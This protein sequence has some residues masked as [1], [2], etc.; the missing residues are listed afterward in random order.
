MFW[1]FVLG[2]VGAI[3]AVPLTITIATLA[4]FFTG[5]VKPAE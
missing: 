3:L 4:P 2:P 5:E 1:A